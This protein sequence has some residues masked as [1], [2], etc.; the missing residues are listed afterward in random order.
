MMVGTMLIQVGLMALD[1]VPPGADAEA[2]RRTRLP[3]ET[4][5]RHRSTI[6]PVDVIERQRRRARG[7]RGRGHATA[8]TP[9]ADGEQVGVVSSAPFGV[10]VVPEVYISSAGIAGGDRSGDAR[11]A[12]PRKVPADRVDDDHLD[13]QAARQRGR[14]TRLP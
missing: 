10:P 9:P 14:R 5:V 13:A 7:R 3:P 8:A 4:R 12:R 1:Q 6:L 11:H 2:V